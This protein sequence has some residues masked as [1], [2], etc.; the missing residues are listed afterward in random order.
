MVEK[1]KD[2]ELGKNE[3]PTLGNCEMEADKVG[4][5]LPKCT[6]IYVQGKVFGTPVWCTVDTGASRTISSSRVYQ[7][8]KDMAGTEI[9]VR[10]QIPIEQADGNLLVNQGVVTVDIQ[11][12][13]HLF[14]DK[15]VVIA[16]IKD[17]VLLGLDIGAT[18][19][20]LSSEGYVKIDGKTVSCT[21]ISRQ[22]V[23]KVSVADEYC[24][25]GYAEKGI[26]VYISPA[27]HEGRR[28]G[29]M[30]LEPTENFAERY[31]LVM[32]RSLVDLTNN[33]TGKVRIVN[34]FDREVVLR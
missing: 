16:N 21:C 1:L 5:R 27:S 2:K 34:P 3:R 30:I 26:E 14:R 8:A 23:G 15:E 17:D 24:I 6:G 7:K 4:R 12:D 10:K 22:M 11:L 18:V 20:V 19:D 28:N 31:S 33:V 32:A 9:Q 29:E 13:N 25:P